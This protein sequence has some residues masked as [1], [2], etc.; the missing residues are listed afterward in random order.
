MKGNGGMPLSRQRDHFGGD[1]ESFGR[2]AV[3]EQQVDH[4]ALAS[5]SDV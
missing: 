3:P 5:A 4:A 2:E 1:V